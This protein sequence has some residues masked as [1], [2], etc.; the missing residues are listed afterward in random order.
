MIPLPPGSSL[1]LGPDDI[2]IAIHRDCQLAGADAESVVGVGAMQIAN[3]PVMVLSRLGPDFADG[4]AGLQA[5]KVHSRLKYYIKGLDC[6]MH[7]I[8]LVTRMV[9][10]RALEGADAKFACSRDIPD[11]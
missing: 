2:E 10:C 1:R 6:D 8:G 9:A 7:M 11:I 3:N 4:P 5:W